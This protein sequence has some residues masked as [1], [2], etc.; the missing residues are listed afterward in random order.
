MK[1]WLKENWIVGATIIFALFLILSFFEPYISDIKVW[2]NE[3]RYYNVVNEIASKQLKGMRYGEDMAVSKLI[4]FK[5][6]AED[7]NFSS[8]EGFALI[9]TGNPD[10]PFITSAE[11]IFT[12]PNDKNRHHIL[13]DI[14]IF[15]NNYDTWVPLTSDLIEFSEG[16][17]KPVS[18]YVMWQGDYKIP[19]FKK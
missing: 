14:Y 17:L 1:N 5:A 3:W 18:R 10:V 9:K 16:K 13:R 6:E 15:D 7:W 2:F 8:Q 12:S 11:F 19:F 4:A